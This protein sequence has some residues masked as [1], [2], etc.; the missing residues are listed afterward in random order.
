MFKNESFIDFTIAENR[1]RFAAMLLDVQ[2]AIDA[3]TL[4]ASPMVDGKKCGSG[5]TIPSLDPSNFDVTLGLVRLASDREAESAL[6]STRSGAT[7]WGNTDFERRAELCKKVGE[8]LRRDRL[9]LAGLIVREAGKNWRE[10]DKDVCE[11]IDFCD[12]YAEEMLRLGPVKLT[13]DVPGEQNSTFYKPRG[14]CVVIA[15]W[16]FPLAIACG[17]TMAALVA[18]NAVILKPAE[19]TSLVADRLARAILDAGIP[20]NAFAF[21]PG[22]GEVIGRML[23]LDPR[24]DMICFTGSKTVGLEIIRSAATVKSGQRSIKRVVA[25]LG[26]KNGLIVDEDADLDEAVKSIIE[27]AFGYSGQKCSACSRVI[28]V[29]DAY[30]PLLQRL[31]DA[32]SDIIIGK[33]ADCATFV[34]PLIDEEA[35]KRVKSVIAEG[36]KHSQLAFKGKAPEHGYFVP[37]TIFRDVDTD[38]PLW[39]EEIFGPVIACRKATD[40]NEALALA[41]D[42]EY[43]LTGG[44]CSRSPRNIELAKRSFLVGNLYINRSIT[45]ALV[46]RQPFGGFRMSGVGSKAGGHDYLLQFMEPR[47]VSENTMRRGF[48]PEA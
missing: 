15:P 27:S 41:N 20:G 19:Q 12:F 22:L 7:A 35:Q 33:A 39:R 14:V 1:A 28:V 34:G 36:E 26:G 30:E 16:N 37:P 44:V 25:E 40:F 47:T 10:A 3:K 11:A 48:A 46:C 23:V 42:S 5:G 8:N 9:F 43:A 45:G 18:G 38:S 17:M 29:G 21:L 6:E 13:E 2:K 32:T 24:V 4:E 31:C